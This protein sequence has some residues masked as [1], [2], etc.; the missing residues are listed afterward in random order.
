ML[1]SHGLLELAL[2]LA[3]LDRRRPRQA[4]LRRAV[5]TAYYA[6]FHLLI[7][8]A[9]EAQVGFGPTSTHRDIGETVARWFTH[10]QIAAICRQFSGP[11]VPSKLRKALPG[12]AQG[13]AASPELQGVAQAFLELQEARHDADYNSAARYSRQEVLTLVSQ[14]ERAFR[15]WSDAAADPFRPIFLL[16]MLTGDSVIKDR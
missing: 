12:L 3:Q 9:V 7:R 8:S 14:T 16:L 10:A 1:I 13:V 11:L 6:L 2:D 15:D 4:S 5:S